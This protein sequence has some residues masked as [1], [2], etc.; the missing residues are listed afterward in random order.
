M[1]VKLKELDHVQHVI[2]KSRN[3]DIT[4]VILFKYELR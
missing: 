3:N 4:I 1:I 2:C